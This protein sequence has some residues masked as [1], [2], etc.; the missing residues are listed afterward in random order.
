MSAIGFRN[1]EIWQNWDYFKIGRPVQ[2]HFML[3]VSNFLM[4][5]QTVGFVRELSD[6]WRQQ[7]KALSDGAGGFFDF[8]NYYPPSQ[9]GDLLVISKFESWDTSSDIQ[10]KIDQLLQELQ[11]LSMC[12]DYPLACVR[13]EYWLLPGQAET[14]KILQAVRRPIVRGVAFEVDERGAAERKIEQD[15]QKYGDQ[16]DSDLQITIGHYL[17]GMTLL[18]L[19]DSYSGLIDAAFMQFYQACE[20][21]AGR[22]W[23]LA[24]VKQWL[25]DNSPANDQALQVTVDHVWYVRHNFF[26]H[27]GQNWRT[28]SYSVYQ[29]AKQVLVARW[30]ARRLIEARVGSSDVLCREVRLYDGARSDEFRGTLQELETSFKIR[31]SGQ[32]IDVY[33]AGQPRSKYLVP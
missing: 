6:R 28:S 20:V 17:T 14:G 15:F 9:Q 1:W 8:S 31:P 26:G 19:E 32:S 3:Y 13:I 10:G 16:S 23:K 5:E 25:A 12:L 33:L 24:Q 29:I 4:A 22:N 21:L 18:S 27:A 11:A 2:G 7:G 30:L